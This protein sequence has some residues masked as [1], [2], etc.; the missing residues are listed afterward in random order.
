MTPPPPGA[1]AGVSLRL[2]AGRLGNR[3]GPMN[4]ASTLMAK[5]LQECPS[6]GELLGCGLQGPQAVSVLCVRLCV[7]SFRKLGL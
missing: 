2:E 1:A 4:I 7:R 3:A 5:A 6:S